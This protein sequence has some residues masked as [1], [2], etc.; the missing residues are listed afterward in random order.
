MFS[1]T[2]QHGLSSTVMAPASLTA[3]NI[4][5]LQTY[6]L[7]PSHIFLK[8]RLEQLITDTQY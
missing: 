8:M 4:E 2:S 1:F 5:L 7:P 6:E 3:P